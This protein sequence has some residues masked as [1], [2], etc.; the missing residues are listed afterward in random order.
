MHVLQDV[1]LMM[2]ML[3]LLGKGFGMQRFKCGTVTA[4]ITIALMRKGFVPTGMGD[5]T[6]GFHVIAARR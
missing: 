3:V 1:F 2:V 5:A 4:T 6:A